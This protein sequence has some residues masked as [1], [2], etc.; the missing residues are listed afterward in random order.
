MYLLIYFSPST[1]WM[2]KIWQFGCFFFYL[3][4]YIFTYLFL[5]NWMLKKI[6]YLCTWFWL[7]ECNK[8]QNLSRWM[9][10][11]FFIPSAFFPSKIRKIPH[12]GE[13]KAGS[14]SPGTHLTLLPSAGSSPFRILQAPNWKTSTLLEWTQLPPSS[15]SAGLRCRSPPHGK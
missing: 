8:I 1:G 3:L 5:D 10:L 14:C 9:L 13:N 7:V 2:L 12:V 6:C 11:F 15:A 4:T